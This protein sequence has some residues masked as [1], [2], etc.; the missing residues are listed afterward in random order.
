MSDS[1][2]ASLKELH[3]LADLIKTSIAT[4]EKACLASQQPFPSPDLP[5][6]PQTEGIR[7]SPE[8]QQAGDI[9]VAAASQLIAAVRPPPMT[10]MVYSLQVCIN[11]VLRI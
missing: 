4:I 11:P 3:A 7:M 8:V 5:F 10:V 9:L 2:Q 1:I 6:N